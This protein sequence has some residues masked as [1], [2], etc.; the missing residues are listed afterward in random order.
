MFGHYEF[1]FYCC[2]RVSSKNGFGLFPVVGLRVRSKPR[3]AHI[4]KVHQLKLTAAPAIKATELGNVF[5]AQEVIDG[6]WVMTTTS[7]YL[8]PRS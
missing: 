8:Y 5:S 7:N 4:Y 1:S 3:H 6:F 2:S